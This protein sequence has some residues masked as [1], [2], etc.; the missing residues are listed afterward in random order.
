MAGSAYSDEALVPVNDNTSLSIP[1]YSIPAC[2]RG[3][4]DD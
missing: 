4:L 2:V 3:A 1:E